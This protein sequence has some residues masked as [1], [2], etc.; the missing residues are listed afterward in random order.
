MSRGTS[1]LISTHILP[2]LEKICSWVSI[3]S[4]G[5]IVDQGYIKDLTA[6]YS[7][8][9]YRIEVS[10]P[11]LL[12]ERIREMEIVEEVWVEGENV[13]CRVKNLDRFYGEIPKI[14]AGLNLQLRSFQLMR[15]SL[16]EI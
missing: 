1:F 12:A 11:H 4:E 14:I 8:N 6:K 5:R 2:E 9:V 16:K 13:Y 3:I 7:A 10:N 15:S